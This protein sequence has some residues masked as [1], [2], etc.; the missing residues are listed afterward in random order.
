MANPFLFVLTDGTGDDNVVGRKKAAF[1]TL[2]QEGVAPDLITFTPFNPT[3]PSQSQVQLVDVINDFSWTQTPAMGRHEVPFVRMSEYRVQ[4]NSLIQNIKYQLTA[5]SGTVQDIAKGGEGA[6]LVNIAA[7]TGVAMKE[8]TEKLAEKVTSKAAVQAVKDQI[9]TDTG[10]DNLPE[11][12]RP[13]YGLYG[14]QPTGFEYYFPYFNTQWKEVASKWGEIEGG[15]LAGAITQ[16]FDKQGTASTLLNT[17]LVDQNTLGAYIERPKMYSYGGD[18]PGITFTLTLNNTNTEDD[19]IRNWHLAFMLAYQNLP[20]KTSKVFLEPPVIYEIE[21]PGQVYYP[22]AYI[23]KVSIIN[24]GSVRVLQLPYYNL[25]GDL[26]PAAID[27]EKNFFRSP[28]RWDHFSSDRA[29]RAVLKKGLWRQIVAADRG[30]YQKSLRLIEAIVPDAYEI[31]I[32]LKSLLPDSKNLLFHSTL[33]SGT[34]GKGIYTANV[35]KT[36]TQ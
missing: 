13:Y 30:A 3:N 16:L 34:L 2:Q 1:N 4:F 29:A 5:F 12:L 17:A 9:S 20:N 28:E 23:D 24:R 31:T 21:V 6:N 25:A 8:V 35:R 36:P 7:E 33:G 32:S 18:A 10:G 15:G 22:Y 11:Y 26:E 27:T 19:I 14:A